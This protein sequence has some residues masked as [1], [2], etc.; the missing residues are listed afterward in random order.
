VGTTVLP[1]SGFLVTCDPPTKQYIK[2]LDKAK[3]ADKKF[4]LED[5][6]A[7]HLLIDGKAKD[8]ILRKVEAW[9]D[10]VSVTFPRPSC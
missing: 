4:I 6:D 1:S 8:E 10:E 3:S 5:L 7:T 2:F 9:M